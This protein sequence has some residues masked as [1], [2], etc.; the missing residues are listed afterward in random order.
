MRKTILTLAAGLLLAGCAEKVPERG[1]LI[2]GEA[3]GF[4]PQ[5]TVVA[6]LFK[7]EG[8]SGRSF[9]KDTLQD[10]HFRFRLDSLPEEADLYH[11]AFEKIKGGHFE[12]FVGI[13]SNIYLE[14]GVR[15]RMKGEGRYYKNAQTKSPLK[16]QKLHDRFMKK[17]SLEDWK[18]QQDNQLQWDELVDEID[19]R[20]DEHLSWPEA[21]RDS[22]AQLYGHLRESRPVISERLM[23]QELELV[24]TE[25][26]GAFALSKLEVLALEV[27]NGRKEFREGVIRA[28]G[29]LTDE[30]KNSPAGMAIMNY[31]NPSKQVYIGDPVPEA[32]FVD[33]EGHPVRLS[34]FQG[35]WVLVD[36]WMRSCG[37][38]IKA[39]PELGA[40]SREL[41]DK[42]NV[43]SINVD[44]E[45]TWRKASEEHGITWNNW[46]DP[47][48]PSGIFRAYGTNAFPT[49]VLISPEGTVDYIM[50]G[51][52]EGKLRSLVTLIK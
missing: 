6:T 46:N 17:M 37:P 18:A 11:L 29:R 32:E 31:L 8:N 10:G 13:G 45:P 3:T 9:A 38:C 14:P 30:Q 44:K 42:L 22:V 35:K 28:Y 19:A 26:I 16:D 49:F 48:G 39:V 33:L 23:R 34:D 20:F 51:Y 7:M 1:A 21:Y 50:T 36:F 24:Q 15:V 47:K 12:K 27:L 25:E 4:N 43:V 52:A 40:L 2:L 41:Q 5:D